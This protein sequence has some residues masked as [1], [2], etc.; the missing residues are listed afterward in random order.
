MGLGIDTGRSGC[1]KSAS[2]CA[3]CWLTGV[4]ARF[5]V[6]RFERGSAEVGIDSGI[7]SDMMLMVYAES[8]GIERKRKR[9]FQGLNPRS[10][11]AGEGKQYM[12]TL[13]CFISISK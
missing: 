2:T 9:V 6:A 5:F 1:E 8:R 13:I 7:G 10:G 11:G 4:R 12:K 3:L